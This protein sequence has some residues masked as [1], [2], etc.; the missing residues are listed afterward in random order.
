MCFVEMASRMGSRPG[1]GIDLLTGWNL[2]DQDHLEEL[3]K[4]VGSTSCRESEVLTD[5]S[6]YKSDQEVVEERR[7]RTL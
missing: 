2:G 3:E 5:I 4:L 1:F 7:K 6:K